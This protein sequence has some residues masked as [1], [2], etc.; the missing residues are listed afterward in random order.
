VPGTG[1]RRPDLAIE[2]VVTS[3]GVDKLEVYRKLGVREVWYWQDGRTQAYVRRGLGYEAVPTSE[4]LPGIDL[5]Q[6]ASFLDRPTASAAIREYR[7]ALR[8]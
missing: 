8:A 6:L 3:G 4:A 1:K 7:A 5:E 2:V